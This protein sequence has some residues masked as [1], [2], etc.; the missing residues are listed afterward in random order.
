MAPKRTLI[1]RRINIQIARQ[2]TA[3]N[4]KKIELRF[5]V[6]M[7][8]SGITLT[9]VEYFMTLMGNKSPFS[10]PTRFYHV[11]KIVSQIIIG[12]ARK[13]VE[14]YRNLMSNSTVISL[15]GS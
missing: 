3:R 5:V 13:N 14:K 6:A 9:Q 7:L 1:A 8:V 12:Y 15:D 4:I 11:Q 2:C 10:S